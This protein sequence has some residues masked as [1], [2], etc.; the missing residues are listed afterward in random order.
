MIL[1]VVPIAAFGAY[2][3]LV[4]NLSSDRDWRES[5]LMASVIW[6]ISAVAL[7]EIL[8][9]LSRLSQEWL[10]LSWLILLFIVLVSLGVLRTRRARLRSPKPR[11]P[12]EPTARIILVAILLIIVI[13]ALVAWISPPNTW[14][15]LTYHM[16]RVAQWDQN[17]T[18][19]HFA[20]GIEAQNFMPPGASIFVLQ[21]YVLGNGDRLAN[22]IQ[23]FAM[24]G[25]LIGISLIAKKLGAGLAGQLVAALFV[26]TLP[27][28]ILQSTSTF[29]DYVVAFWVI[30]VAYW[31]IEAFD[32]VP[33]ESGL[34]IVGGGAG[35]ALLTK[36]TS[37]PYLIPLGFLTALGFFKSSRKLSRS[38]QAISVEMLTR[39]GQ[40]PDRGNG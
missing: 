16:S 12:A 11:I 32:G 4:H 30:C 26:A 2:L 35:L 34:L 33:K 17:Q 23:W 1:V 40:S 10:A 27:T 13:T 3:L 6:G 25:S 31:A 39:T 29:N 37:L 8:S 20:T 14:D 5:F 7:A 28:G 19:N 24:V 22:F 21:F 18:L 38:T 36:Q 15:A 9:A